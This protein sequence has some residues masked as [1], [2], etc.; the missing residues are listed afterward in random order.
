M[1]E[2]VFQVSS[3]DSQF[4]AIHKNDAFNRSAANTSGVAAFMMACNFMDTE[5]LV[6]DASKELIG[7][8]WS[9]RAEARPV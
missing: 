4:F 7:I 2:A 8:Y 6:I 3:L 5:P 9:S 1:Q